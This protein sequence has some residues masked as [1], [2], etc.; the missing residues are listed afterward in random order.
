VGRFYLQSDTARIVPIT[1]RE[2]CL[3]CFSGLTILETEVQRVVLECS[4]LSFTSSAGLRVFLTTVKRMKSRGGTCAFASLTPSVRD[5]FEMA[6]F[7]DTMEV[8]A[9]RESALVPENL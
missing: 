8:H 3:K 9:S 7:L 4:E 2:N 6:G 5:V 1:F